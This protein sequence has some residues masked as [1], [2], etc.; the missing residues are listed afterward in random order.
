M[1]VLIISLKYKKNIE[2]SRYNKL[3]KNLNTNL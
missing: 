2:F 1:K 3:Y